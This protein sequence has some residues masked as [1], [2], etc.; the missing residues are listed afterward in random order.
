MLAGPMRRVLILGGTGWLGSEIAREAAS[1]GAEVVCL[2]RGTSGT[3]PDGT[4]LIRADR[5]EPG[6][7]DQL[8]G[9]WD[10][11]IELSDDPSFVE[12]A[13][14][15]LA[16][17][18]RHWTF[19]STVSVYARN[20]EPDADESAELLRPHDLNE[21][22]EAKV[23][24]EQATVRRLADRSLILRPGLI[25]GPGDP[26]DRF[27]YWPARL[28]RGGTVL[29]PTTAGRF[30]QVID[31]TDLATFIVKAGHDQLSGVVNAVG[32]QHTMAS[33]FTAV[34]DV[35]GFRGDI[36]HVDDAWLAEHHVNHWAGPRSLPLWLPSSDAALAQR[37]NAAFRAAGGSLL[38]LR[39]TIERVLLDEVRR[40]VSRPR[41]A[42][43]TAQEESGLLDEREQ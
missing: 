16:S 28:S 34:A 42:G 18:A 25:A 19:V 40:G 30:V 37:S 14:D 11:V 17:R 29:A 32:D 9:D 27:G 4:V 20:D 26:S 13:L 22:G 39:E 43:L 5:Q 8:T 6:A 10:D 33:F 21:Y 7:Y 15:A 38:P 31:V 41:R 35:A 12:S 36:A 1:N 3:V 23:A 2:A 24:A